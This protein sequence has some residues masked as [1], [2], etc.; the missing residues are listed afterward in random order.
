MLF[1]VHIKSIFILVANQ[2]PYN[3]L[4]FS[5]TAFLLLVTLFSLPSS[6]VYNC[7][8]HPEDQAEMFDVFLPHLS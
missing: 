8:N 4:L 7:P 6:N 5:L 2:A 1:C 3:P